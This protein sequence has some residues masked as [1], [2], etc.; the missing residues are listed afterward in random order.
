MTEGD[1]KRAHNYSLFL[2]RENRERKRRK[3]ERERETGGEGGCVFYYK[4]LFS[5]WCL[6]LGFFWFT[7]LSAEEREKFLSFSLSLFSLDVEREKQREKKEKGIRV[8]V[9]GTWKR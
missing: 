9:V 8:F 2:E 4:F 7:L 6:F 3:I 5:P 1:L